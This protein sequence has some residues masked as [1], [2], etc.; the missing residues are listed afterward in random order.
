[1]STATMVGSTASTRSDVD[2]LGRRFKVG[3]ETVC[4]RLSTLQR[5]Q[6]RGVPFIVVRTD[7]A[8]N[9]SK[10]QS[11]ESFHFSRAGGS[12]PLW[13]VHD[14]FAQPG[15]IVVQ[16][17]QMPDWP[18]ISLGRQDQ[19]ARRSRLPGSAQE[20]RDRPGMQ[21]CSCRQTR[22]ANGFRPR[23]PDHGGSYRR[24]LQDLQSDVMCPARV[25]PSR[26]PGRRRR[27][28]GLQAALFVHGSIRLTTPNSTGIR[29]PMILIGVV[30]CWAHNRDQGAR[31]GGC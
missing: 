24:G 2:L 10:R 14:S 5:P 13:M 20:L 17:A 9:I 22:L 31:H 29:S 27:E 6:Q 3:F 19:R 16:V 28:R 18:L 7:K 15:R 8:G 23:R 11:A 12:Y 30:C 4:H 25:P 1:M 21:S 26:R